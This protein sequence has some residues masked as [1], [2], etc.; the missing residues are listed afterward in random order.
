MSKVIATIGPG[1][2]SK[3]RIRK[4]SELGVKIFRLNL[5]H[6]SIEWHIKVINNIREVSPSSSI[7]AD[8]PGRKIRTTFNVSKERFKKAQTIYLVSNDFTADCLKSKFIYEVNNNILFTMAKKGM[9]IYADDGRLSFYVEN[10]SLILHSVL[11]HNSM[12]KRS[13]NE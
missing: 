6:N 4:L 3:E 9:K 5:S 1:T 7:L 12:L 8:I 10:P 11:H 13:K 2:E